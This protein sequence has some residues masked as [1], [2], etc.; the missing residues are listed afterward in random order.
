MTEGPSV[1]TVSDTA[2]EATRSLLSQVP[3]VGEALAIVVRDTY[4]RRVA[5]AEDTVA[6][7]AAGA[8]GVERLH[9]R[10]SQEP[11][12]DSLFIE[13]VEAAART[14]LHDKR[15]LLAQIVSAAV[16]D[17]AKLD[18]AQLVVQA[19]RDLDA[20]QI[21]AL[22]TARRFEDASLRDIDGGINLRVIDG[23]MVRKVELRYRERTGDDISSLVVLRNEIVI[24]AVHGLDGPVAAAL[25]RTGTLHVEFVADGARVSV[26]RFGRR[27]LDDLR[28]DERTESD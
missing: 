11:M 19:L 22:E 21:R 28:G 10:L 12:L 25:V 1:P 4:S 16:L 27:L 23:G 8:G 6:E 24:E 18:E 7:I 15:K 2:V 13:A 14:G 17:D 26:T 20:P 3:V 5:K 9:A